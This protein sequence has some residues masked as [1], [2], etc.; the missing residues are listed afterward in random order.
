MTENNKIIMQ[1]EEFKEIL[2]TYAGRK[3]IKSI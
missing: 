2:F 3:A 1:A